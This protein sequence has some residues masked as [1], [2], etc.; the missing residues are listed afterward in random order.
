MDTANLPRETQLTANELAALADDIKRWGTQ[1][2]FGQIGVSDIDLSVAET[3]L[4]EWLAEGFHGEMRYFDRHGIRRARPAEL[5]PGTVRVI[6]A[7]L[8]YSALGAQDSQSV[9]D[10]GTLAFVSR[11]AL[12]RDYHK[13]MRG[14]LQR[15]AD[16]I[17][18]EIG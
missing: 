14:R 15:L 16:R 12:G 13:V 1:L 10:D 6:C 11:Y 8:D 5:V 2:G 9:L 18:G 17:A 4:L 3:R 7:R